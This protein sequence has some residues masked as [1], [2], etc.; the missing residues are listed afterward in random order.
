MTMST[1]NK[2]PENSPTEQQLSAQVEEIINKADTMKNAQESK[3]PKDSQNMDKSKSKEKQS[4]APETQFS[5]INA[6]E[7]TSLKS[8][9][10]L[11]SIVLFIVVI[12][13]G[14]FGFYSYDTIRKLTIKDG[15]YTLAQE[16]LNHAKAMLTDSTNK[17]STLIED[18]KKLYEQNQ[19]LDQSYNEL[20]ANVNKLTQ[21][22][23]E[24]LNAVVT[25]NDRI[26]KYEDRNPFEWKLSEAFYLINQAQNL[27]LMS[28]NIQS[29]IF[30]LKTADQA[31]KDINDNDIIKLREQIFKDISLLSSLPKLETIG[32]GL[33]LEALI[34]N[35]NGFVLS[36]YVDPKS[37]EQKTQSNQ[38]SDNV[39]DWKSN[40]LQS[41][42]D[43]SLKFIE[44]RK[45]T[46]DHAVEFIS[47]DQAMFLKENIK[48][49]LLMAKQEAYNHDEQNYKRNLNECLGLIND[50]FDKDVPSTNYAIEEIKALVKMPVTVDTPDTLSSFAYINNIFKN[51]TPSISGAK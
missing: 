33:R 49:R 44:I 21:D 47:P 31:L 20:L 10:T 38:V 4:I 34:Y 50:Y 5:Y 1:E 23:N 15:S 35:V 51:K 7:V 25:V 27:G 36:G 32:I 19:R 18:N 16:Q 14:A 22:Y 28:N 30:Y 24:T 48:T 9:L 41:A 13:F 43:F 8:K 39:A 42:K 6:L 2:K 46:S 12:L 3:E 29:A 26:K 45:R 11:L 40:I 37:L 17:V